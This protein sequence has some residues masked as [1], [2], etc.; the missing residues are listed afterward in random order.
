MTN[1]LVLHPC[2]S[3]FNPPTIITLGV[4]LFLPCTRLSLVTVYIIYYIFYYYKLCF[5]SYTHLSRH[6]CV[7]RLHHISSR[8]QKRLSVVDIC[9]KR[10]SWLTLLKTHAFE[11]K[12]S[13]FFCLCL[14][15]QTLTRKCSTFSKSNFSYNIGIWTQTLLPFPQ[16]N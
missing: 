8:R 7:V 15:S 10:G 13:S 14:R 16:P 2:T 3:E 6:A 1:K 11:N 12:L 9:S 4:L 5:S